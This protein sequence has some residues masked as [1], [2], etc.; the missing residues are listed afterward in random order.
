VNFNQTNSDE[1]VDERLR[2]TQPQELK[3]WS[4]FTVTHSTWSCK[5]VVSLKRC[6]PHFESSHL[7]LGDPPGDERSRDVVPDLAHELEAIKVW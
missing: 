4:R 7:A 5:F 1:V 3:S 2:P 6:R